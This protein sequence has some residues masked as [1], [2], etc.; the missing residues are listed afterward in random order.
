[1]VISRR[2]DHVKQL[3]KTSK[4]AAELE[5]QLKATFQKDQFLEADTKGAGVTVV[6]V[7]L[8]NTT[9]F[10]L[11]SITEELARNAELDED[12]EDRL[13]KYKVMNLKSMQRDIAITDFSTQVLFQIITNN[14][15]TLRYRWDI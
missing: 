5:A 2:N 13:D 10:S 15:R 6:N 12:N 14:G 1:M 8:D 4:Y 7:P 3:L 9:F 11:A